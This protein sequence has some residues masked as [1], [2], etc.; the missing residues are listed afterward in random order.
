[1]SRACMK[2]LALISYIVHSQ[3][4]LLRTLVNFREKNAARYFL[5]LCGEGARNVFRLFVGIVLESYFFSISEV[6]LDFVSFPRLSK[7]FVS[8]VHAIT[9][10]QDFLLKCLKMMFPVFF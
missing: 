8:I 6:Y 5:I 3:E 10:Y 1:M 9:V 2:D 7:M 4:Q